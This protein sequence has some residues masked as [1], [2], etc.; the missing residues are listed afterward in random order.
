MW[1]EAARFI[2][3]DVKIVLHAA[4]CQA[5]GFHHGKQLGCQFGFAISPVW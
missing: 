4:V 5:C 2:R 3:G 1:A